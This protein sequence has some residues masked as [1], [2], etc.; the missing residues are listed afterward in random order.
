V[1]QRKQSFTLFFIAGIAILI[2][3]ITVLTSFQQHINTGSLQQAEIRF[4]FLPFTQAVSL[5]V[6][7]KNNGQLQAIEYNRY[8]LVV[9]SVRNGKVTQAETTNIFKKIEDVDFQEAVRR[10]S[11]AGN[12]T[13]QGDLFYVQIKTDNNSTDE[14]AGLV[15]HAPGTIKAILESLTGL[16]KQLP[17]SASDEAYA[18]SNPIEKTRFDNLKQAGKLRFISLNDLSPDL[19]LPVSTAINHPADFQPVNRTQYLELLALASHG[20]DLFVID[21]STGHQL[22][23][24]TSERK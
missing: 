16:T 12:G 19:Q 17:Q 8:Q 5:Y 22:T 15:H 2:S 14:I 20:H 6:I 23:L 10:K 21:G 11:F 9:L 18:R 7:L 4:E 24:F 3:G 13:E 1:F